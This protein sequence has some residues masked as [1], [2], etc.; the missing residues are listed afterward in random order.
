MIHLEQTNQLLC[1]SDYVLKKKLLQNTVWTGLEHGVLHSHMIMSHPWFLSSKSPLNIIIN[2][3][4]CWTAN[5]NNTW[6]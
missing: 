2:K 6:P 1:E 4:T 3:Y 5:M